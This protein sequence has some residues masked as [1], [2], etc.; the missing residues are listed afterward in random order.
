MV[1]LDRFFFIWEIKEVVAGRVKQVIVI[2]SNDCTGI[3]LGGLGIG[4][5]NEVVVL[6]RWSSEH[7]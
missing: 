1:V 5:L 4:H 7:V 6:Q 2:Y 3:R